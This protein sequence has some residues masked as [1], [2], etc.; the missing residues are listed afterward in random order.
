[1][2]SGSSPHTGA[3][4]RDGLVALGIAALVAATVLTA[5]LVPAAT[6]HPA[7]A[8]SIDERCAEW[9]DGCRICQRT[10]EGVACSTP[11]IACV[12]TPTSCLRKIGS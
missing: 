5:H 3:A 1:M 12:P 10:P 4:P 6:R 7:T 2:A 11:G 8:S 9:S